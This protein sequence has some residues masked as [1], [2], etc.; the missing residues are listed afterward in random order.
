M[1]TKITLDDV[2]KLIASHKREN[3]KALAALSVRMI[4]QEEE[5][6]RLFTEYAVTQDPTISTRDLLDKIKIRDLEYW[7]TPLVDI[8]GY[9]D[10]PERVRNF[11]EF[12][13]Y[14]G[15][16]ATLDRT[17]PLRGSNFGRNS[18]KKL[19]TW[20]NGLGEQ[21]GQELIEYQ[22]NQTLLKHFDIKITHKEDG[23]S[24]Y[25]KLQY[26]RY[27]KLIS[28]K[29]FTIGQ[30]CISRETYKAMSDVDIAAIETYLKQWDDHLRLGMPLPYRPE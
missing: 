28:M 14:L 16:L 21:L 27:K 17:I 8:S 11:L 10:L 15:D 12:Y 6:T 25:R 3:K 1:T 23:L 18:L 26:D 9:D 2:L 7:Y 19:E 5:L 4:A 30:L 29:I 20:M 22:E 24:S 13:K